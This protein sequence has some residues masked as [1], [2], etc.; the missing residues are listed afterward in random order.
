MRITTAATLAGM[1]IG[2]GSAPPAFAAAAGTVTQVLGR[3]TVASADGN[4]RKIKK[5]T[6]I[7]EGA[8]I[9]TGSGSFAKIKFE[10][11]GSIFLRPST[12]FRVDAFENSGGKKKEEKSFFS[13]LKG[14]LRFVTG[15]IAKRNRNAYRVN[16]PTATIGIRG[17]DGAL[18]LDGDGVH[19]RV[20]DGEV[21]IT[22][23]TG[24]QLSTPAGKAAFASGAGTVQETDPNDS[25]ITADNFPDPD[26]DAPAA[27][28]TP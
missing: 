27:D 6:G 20:F 2:L 24:A 19:L 8:T 17:T 11:G 15:L 9:N 10:D 23:A 26:G 21:V 4:I 14:G 16:T 25:P 1:L 3:V 5:G 22:T 12:R 28:C 18:L 7:D 13:L